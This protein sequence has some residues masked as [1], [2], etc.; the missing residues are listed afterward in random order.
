M[1]MDERQK[2][3]LDHIHRDIYGPSK[4][5]IAAIMVGR[6]FVF[7]TKVTVAGIIVALIWRHFNK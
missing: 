2:R 7:M 4:I 1:T 3:I 5:E 6:T